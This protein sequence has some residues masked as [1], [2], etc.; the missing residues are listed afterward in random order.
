VL[1]PGFSNDENQEKSELPSYISKFHS[2]ADEFLKENIPYCQCQIDNKK[3]IYGTQKGGIVIIND[4]GELIQVINSPRG[5]QDNGVRALIADHNQ[6]L[7]AALNYGFSYIEI[8]SPITQFNALN[9]LEG[10]VLTVTR[11]QGQLYAGTFNGIFYLP[12]NHQ[13][14]IDGQLNFLPIKNTK[15]F[16][17]NFFSKHNVLLGLGGEGVYHIINDAGFLIS[18]IRNPY[19]FGYTDQFPHHIFIGTNTGLKALSIKN[20][21]W[22]NSQEL[23]IV[24]II[25]SNHFQ[26]F[27]EAIRNIITDNQGNLWLS[28]EVNGI[29][30][31]K[32]NN[33]KIDDFVWQR[34]KLEDGLPGMVSN[35]VYVF[36][37]RINLA[38]A[39]GIYK[40]VNPYPDKNSSGSIRFEPDCEH[41]NY[42]C[43]NKFYI[44][45]IV[46]VKNK[47]YYIFSA[48]GLGTWKP[49][50]TGVYQWD[51]QPFKKISG[52]I[53]Q[54]F[55]DEDGPVW[56]CGVDS[57]CLWRFDP[58]IKK[59]YAGQF[60][61]LIR[62]VSAGKEKKI[63]FWGNYYDSNQKKDDIFITSS[64]IQPEEMNI[65][66]PFKQN[67]LY[68]DYC[69]TFY[70]HAQRL[71]YV[72]Y[73]DGF[74]ESWS[75][76]TLET[77]KEYSN[78]PEGKYSFQVKC[79]NVFGNESSV[80]SFRF[81]ITPP[82]QRTSWAYLGYLVL[83]ILIF[84]GGIRLNS[85]RLVAAKVRL[86]QIVSERTEEVIKQRDEIT[87]Q[88]DEISLKNIEITR[89][90]DKLEAFANNLYKT[91]Q[92]LEETNWQLKTTKDAL[93]GE[94]ELAKKI[95]TVLLPKSPVI[96]GYEI[97]A[98]MKP[99]D[100]VGGDYYD[101]ICI[102][103]ND[104]RGGACLHPD[105]ERD[106]EKDG[107]P[108]RGGS[109]ARPQD[110]GQSPKTN[111]KNPSNLFIGKLS[112]FAPIDPSTLYHLSSNLYP[113]YWLAIGDV[114]GHGVSAG[115]V[116]MMLQTSI[117]TAL[118]TY[119]HESPMQILE[120]VNTI[121]HE[122]IKKL[123]EDKYVTLTL[124]SVQDNGHFYFSG[125]HQDIL[126]FRSQKNQVEWIETRGMWLGIMEDVK[127]EMLVDR[128]ILAPGDIMLLYTD[129]IPEAT[130]QQGKMYNGEKLAA[131][132]EKNGR[133]SPGKIKST[134]VESLKNYKCNDDV[135]MLII[136][137][138]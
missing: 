17:F 121:I 69:A 100:E 18:H 90:K 26:D 84:Y 37:D 13:K 115:L 55:A 133:Q 12:R 50:K 36:D 91:N 135:T 134:L 67:S 97:D 99:A 34:F 28:S 132:F 123:G 8:S 104:R 60:P 16:C 24:D 38:T 89:Q 3:Y 75:E 81:R 78:L 19:C 14:S 33:S 79:T 48:Q 110:S 119:A 72:Y 98:Y 61:T 52:Q 129:G 113:S 54:I 138:L 122:N 20:L 63:L 49:D 92:Q 42:F 130:D 1:N 45:H 9:K 114:S 118:K 83:V 93:W 85:Q 58:N 5:L 10:I 11:H 57:R 22:P 43:Q 105:S 82:W 71:R 96:P 39:A 21:L 30:K 111:P 108:C 53:E 127:G 7:W 44:T 86:E 76:P 56:F 31:V 40:V 41:F 80:A 74:D 107:E 95:Q 64:L 66:L 136:K 128:V 35:Y 47:I 4:H 137:R 88:K 70:E 116:M 131:L 46:R 102:D 73:L 65:K 27:N 2:Q 87:L 25:D 6:N 120:I 117:R 32:W 101:V 112:E 126:V 106:E 68:F 15:T 125:L 94:M 29:I 77:K 62:S 59:K 103:N 124:L 109:C 23:L 51:T